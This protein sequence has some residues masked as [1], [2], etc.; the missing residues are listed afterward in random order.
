M[1]AVSKGATAAAAKHVEGVITHA[2]FPARGNKGNAFLTHTTR[3][4]TIYERLGKLYTGADV[5][6]VLPGTMGTLAELM[7]TWNVA[8]V[9]HAFA[10]KPCPP[11]LAFKTPW[12][13]VINATVDALGDG[14]ISTGKLCEHDVESGEATARPA[15]RRRALKKINSRTHAFA[16]TALT[17][18]QATLKRSRSSTT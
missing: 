12:Q 18:R 6:I 5:F 10:N 17:L 1:E 4:T 11:M 8:T 15:S 7:V 9:E 3:T 2:A 13:T 14:G 16:K